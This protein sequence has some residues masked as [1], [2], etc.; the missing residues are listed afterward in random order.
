MIAF[1][2]TYLKSNHLLKKGCANSSFIHGACANCFRELY[3]NYRIYHAEELDE[4]GYPVIDPD[5]TIDKFNL[6][7]KSHTKNLLRGH[8]ASS[9]YPAWYICLDISQDYI[10]R[11]VDRKILLIWILTPPPPKKKN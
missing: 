9:S 4:E 6:V 2:I 5:I 1:R 3:F 10:V 7:T 11:F 8:K